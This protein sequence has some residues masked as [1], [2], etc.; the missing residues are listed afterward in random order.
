MKLIATLILICLLA[1]GLGMAVVKHGEPKKDK[2]NFW[3]QL[4]ATIIE[5]ILFYY[6]GLFDIFIN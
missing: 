4:F 2:W 6:A 1:M 3:S 5:V